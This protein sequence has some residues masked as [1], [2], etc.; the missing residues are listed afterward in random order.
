MRIGGCAAFLFLTVTR[1]GT[2]LENFLNENKD[3]TITYESDTSATLTTNQHGAYFTVTFKADRTGTYALRYGRDCNTATLSD[4]LPQMGSINRNT[5]VVVPILI[6]DVAS[7]NYA[8]L[9]CVADSANYKKASY[10][11]SIPASVLE[12][13]AY[14][15]NETTGGSGA[16]VDS[17]VTSAFVLFQAAQASPSWTN[18]TS[19][20]G[21]ASPAQNSAS[22]PYGMFAGIDI[23][24]GYKLKFFVSDR[25]N[26]R[27]LIFNSV[28]TSNS[29][30][31]DV[32]VGQ[33]TFGTAG[34]NGGFGAPNALGFDGPLNAAVCAN[35]TM[36][37][38]DR[39]NNRVAGYNRVPTANGAAM[40]FV[41]GQTSLTAGL[42]NQ[43]GT[44]NANTL[45][46]PY[47]AACIQSRLVV[48]DSNNNRVLFYSGIPNA[49]NAFAAFALGQPDLVSNSNAQFDWTTN[50]QYTIEPYQTGRHETSG[51][52][53]VAEP[54]NNRVLVYG[55]MPTAAGAKP[56]YA[57]GQSSANQRT[58]NQGAGAGVPSQT[59][60]DAPKSIAFRGAKLAIGDED[61]ERVLFFDLPITGFAPAATHL[62]G[63]NSFTDGVSKTAQQATFG[64]IG[65]LGL[66]DLLFDGN[67]I[68]VHDG[69][70][71]R[72]QIIPLPF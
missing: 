58:A 1:C 10:T 4:K 16:A 49:T 61:N 20:R 53:F 70:Y 25:N 36:F 35:G 43:G 72:Q 63:R 15:Q 2:G 24:D 13:L 64:V 52:F 27:V 22:V 39:N 71:H 48:A 57:I 26:H 32:V 41:V 66:K 18:V 7:A 8:F 38:S 37:V 6:T 12:N 69:A 11:K 46:F 67:Y 14:L 60:L 47:Q 59:S 62:L 68:R 50:A 19:N 55:A 23:N 3:I 28:P 54:S 51:Q 45:N 40:D 56:V 42:A 5:S 29:A 30:V 44:P 34:S 17:G 21:I 65:L 9:I 31:P 33:T